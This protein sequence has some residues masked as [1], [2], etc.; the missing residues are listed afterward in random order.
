[1]YGMGRLPGPGEWH[2][3]ASTV[4]SAAVSD[5]VSSAYSIHKIST[6]CRAMQQVAMNSKQDL[7]GLEASILEDQKGFGI[8]RLVWTSSQ[9]YHLSCTHKNIETRKLCSSYWSHT[10]GAALQTC[11]SLPLLSPTQRL[12]SGV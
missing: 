11:H 7:W 2:A 9:V 5:M 8:M 10:A 1:M 3:K 4:E 12:R 6:S